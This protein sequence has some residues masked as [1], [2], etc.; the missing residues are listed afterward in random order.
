MDKDDLSG[1]EF[2]RAPGTTT[3]STPAS[4]SPNLNPLLGQNDSTWSNVSNRCESG[5]PESVNELT[6]KDWGSSASAAPNFTDLVPEFEPGKPWKV[7]IRQVVC[8][9]PP[10]NGVYFAYCVLSSFAVSRVVK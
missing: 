2:S 3:K 6:D 1:N 10:E 7:S 9:R 5:W 4:G 8:I